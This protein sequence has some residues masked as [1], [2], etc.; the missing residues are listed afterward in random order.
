M[1]LPRHAALALLTKCTG[2]EIWSVEHCRDAG[3][4]ATWIEELADTFESGFRSDNQTIYVDEAVTNQYRGVRDLDLA[5][6]IAQSL[7]LDIDRITA[8]AM[9]RRAMVQAIKESIMDGD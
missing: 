2:E 9:G 7:G 3:V 1:K 6:R 4:P 5:I 8:T